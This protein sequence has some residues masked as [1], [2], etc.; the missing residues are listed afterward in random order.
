MRPV[1][2]GLV[3]ALWAGRALAAEPTFAELNAA[4]GVKLWQDDSLWDDGAGEVAGRLGWLPESQTE[5]LRS[6]RLYPLGEYRL[7]GAQV[8]SAALYAETGKVSQVSLI[9]INKGDY[10][11]VRLRSGMSRE[12]LREWEQERRRRL[13][14]FSSAFRKERDRIESALNKTLGASARDRFGAAAATSESVRRWDWA[15]HSLL[16]ATPNQDYIALRIVPTAW[17]DA[18]GKTTRVSD[19]KL[20]EQLA[21]RV[22]RRPNGDVIV[23]QIPMVDQGAKGY[24]VPATWERYLRYVGIPADMYALA[25][26]G[27]TEWG[28]GT[29]LDEMARAVTGLISR[30]GRRL[31]KI[32]RSVSISAVAGYVDK[33]LPVMW[34]MYQQAD[35]DYQISHR[36]GARRAVTD[37]A[38]W[39]ERL[40]EARRAARRFPYDKESSGHM[41]L[42]IGY[43][44]A[45]AE[46]AISDSW[47]PEFAERWLTIEEARH[48][49]Q[50]TFYVI[51]W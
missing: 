43:N 28:G 32:N 50:G 1:A 20:R 17:A 25:M 9:F 27:E 42:I 29:Y 4:L 45:T 31:E 51:N 3:V 30:S 11:G 8:Y 14:G 35:L 2:L 13:Q 39:T 7:L 41:C 34:G 15:G 46:L 19:S 49:D 33:G 21:R 47:G 40:K 10:A 6:Y 36:S 44:A 48:L 23:T 22:V 16:L 5:T 12:A 18:E 24:C 26:A 38:Q 37:W